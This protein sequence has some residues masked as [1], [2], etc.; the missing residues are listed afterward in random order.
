MKRLRL[1][2]LIVGV[3]LLG[4]LELQPVLKS[5]NREPRYQGRTLTQWLQD[6]SD[7]LGLPAKDKQAAARLDA[8][9]DAVRAIGPNALPF[10]LKNMAA[11]DSALERHL[12]SL[13]GWQSLVQFHFTDHQQER[14]L[15]WHGFEILGHGATGAVSKLAGMLKSPD[16]DVRYS[17]LI[18]LDHIQPRLKL[19]QPVL[20]QTLKDPHLQV[21]TL[22]T[23]VLEKLC[24]REA[25]LKNV[26]RYYPDFNRASPVSVT[27]NAPIGI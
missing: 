17:A 12:K 4:G 21:R 6:Y 9:I 10:L 8:S 14:Y 1:P 18:C 22:S 5:R 27:T 13:V 11:K 25:D 3:L 15:A 16:A 24:R 20:V 19:I 2:L 7:A 26:D 23:N